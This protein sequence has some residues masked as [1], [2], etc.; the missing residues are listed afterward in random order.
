M[1]MSWQAGSDEAELLRLV[2][3]AGASPPEWVL[4]AGRAAYDWLSIDLELQ[5]LL[6]GTAGPDRSRPA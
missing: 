3:E 5:V 1:D 2:D 6:E 4:V